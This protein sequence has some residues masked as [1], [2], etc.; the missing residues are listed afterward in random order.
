M[1]LITRA[2]WQ[3][4]K[5]L[6]DGGKPAVTAKANSRSK[7]WKIHPSNLGPGLCDRKACYSI[8]EDMDQIEA[9]IPYT[10][11]EELSFRVGH[12]FQDYVAQALEW[13]GALIDTEVLLEGPSDIGHAD[14]ILDPDPLFE[15][16]EHQGELNDTFWVLDVKAVRFKDLTR[17]A[18]YPNGYNI[19]QLERYATL[20]EET[21]GYCHRPMLYVMTRLD[22]QGQ[23][24]HWQWHK[25]GD[26]SAYRWGDNLSFKEIE[27]LRG[28]I[29]DSYESQLQWLKGGLLPD[30]C[31]DTPDEHPFLCVDKKARKGWATPKCKYYRRC[32]DTD[33]LEPYEIGQWETEYIPL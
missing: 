15:D 16:G 2:V 17:V 29:A 23:L 28:Q 10:P 6:S 14:I 5:H 33:T 4:T 3:Y 9:D 24:Y 19:A 30:R 21:T 22:M 12:I 26:C 25:N 18:Y 1:D 27:D 7:K 31:G 11:E 20:L 8:M 13:K 32:W